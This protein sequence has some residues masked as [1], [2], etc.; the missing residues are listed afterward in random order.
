MQRKKGKEKMINITDEQKEL[1]LKY[2]PNTEKILETDEVND[3]LDLL[4]DKITEIGFDKNWNLNKVGL[5][6]Q[7]LYDD[8]YY[9]N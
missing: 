4:D 3:I 1:L 2:L 9:Q 8:I 5:K 7:R 6:L